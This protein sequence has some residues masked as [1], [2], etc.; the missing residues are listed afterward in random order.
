[1]RLGIAHDGYI[2]RGILLKVLDDV[3]HCRK[4]VNAANPILSSFNTKQ[5]TD[6]SMSLDEPQNDPVLGKLSL[7]F[8]QHLGAR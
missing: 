5:V 8:Q 6:G 1:L 3:S 4:P 2:S 7:K